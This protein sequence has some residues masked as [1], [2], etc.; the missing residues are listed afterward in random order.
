MQMPLSHAAMRTCSTSPKLV[1]RLL[2]QALT[3]SMQHVLQV[4]TGTMRV[5]GGGGTSAGERHVGEGGVVWKGLSTHVEHVR[6]IA[7]QVSSWEHVKETAAACVEG[8][9]GQTPAGRGHS[10]LCY[11][12]GYLQS[13]VHSVWYAAEW[14][15]FCHPHE[16]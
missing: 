3:R 10:I 1:V 14:A 8:S 9:R 4:M 13:R 15:T 12:M 16:S 11:R 5:E 2:R 6:A 7:R